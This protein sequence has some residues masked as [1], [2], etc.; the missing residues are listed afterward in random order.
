MIAD[1][2][3]GHGTPPSAETTAT[4]PSWPR[5]LMYHSIARPVEDPNR[6]CVSAR[7][8]SAQMRC[9]R[10]RGLRG[11]SM[12]ELLRASGKDRASGLV[13]LTF[14]DAYEDF[15]GAAVPVLERYGFSATVF[16]IGGMLG[17]ENTWDERPRM[18]LL[19]AAGLREAADRGM[20]VGSHGMTHARLAGVSR[21]RLE[22]EIFES[23]RVLG[24]VLD[25][26]IEGFCYP[27]GSVDEAAA[28]A[29]RRAG[30]SYACACWTRVTDDLHDLPRSPVWEMDG[31][32]MLAAKLN[33]F[34]AYFDRTSL[35][36]QRK[37]D[38][39]G[40][41]AYRNAKRLA[42]RLGVW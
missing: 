2:S 4:Y 31:P 39:I 15:L 11:V 30:Y 8:F 25:R 32:L 28:L 24:A 10:R 23:R 29:A 34:P 18:R 5:V 35:P 42:R 17:G 27:Y 3:I 22:R 13:G 7:R 19:G 12:R 33:L 21:A 36:T 20:E 41:L 38:G 26:D 1:R 16:A 6:I 9:L 40:R 37:L 14:D